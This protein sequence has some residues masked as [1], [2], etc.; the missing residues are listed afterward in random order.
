VKETKA[1]LVKRLEK[2]F[3]VEKD[4]PGYLG[5]PRSFGAVELI[6]RLRPSAKRRKAAIASK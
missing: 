3:A 6:A 1:Q 4:F 5:N 2:I